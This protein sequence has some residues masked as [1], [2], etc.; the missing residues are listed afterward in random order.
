MKATSAPSMSYPKT[1]FSS[2]STNLK[3]ARP[4]TMVLRL[5]LRLEAGAVVGE[6][7]DA[8]VAEGDAVA[9]EQEGV[10]G[11]WDGRLWP[12]RSQKEG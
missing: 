11:E 3:S 2:N 5:V 6:E 12:S 10:A 9:G 8:V 4:A 7:G 1:L